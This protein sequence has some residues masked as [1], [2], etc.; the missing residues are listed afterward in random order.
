MFCLDFKRILRVFTCNLRH[1]TKKIGQIETY[2]SNVD[3]RG[4]IVRYHAVLAALTTVKYDLLTLYVTI[5]SGGLTAMKTSL[6]L[7]L[8]TDTQRWLTYSAYQIKQ[9]LSAFPGSSV[10]RRQRQ[11]STSTTRRDKVC[12]SSLYMISKKLK[13]AIQHAQH[14]TR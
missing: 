9:I 6:L 2:M 14:T 5:R 7:P 3:M 11:S 4:E 8:L 13:R 1:L 12:I 10:N